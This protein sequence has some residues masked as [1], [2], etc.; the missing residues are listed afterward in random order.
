MQ[1]STGNMM[2][3]IT[4]MQEDADKRRQEVLD[5][6]DRLSDASSSD[7]AST[8]SRMYSGSHNSSISISMLPSEPKIFHGRESELSDILELFS[9]ETPRIAILGPGGIGKT[10]MARAIVHHQEIS[11][12]YRQHRFFVSCD[13]VVNKAELVAL[14]GAHL[15]LK[16][17]KDLTRPIVQH[18][19][20]SPPSLIVLDNLETLWESPGSR[21]DVEE[22]LSLVTDVEQ[23]SLLVGVGLISHEALLIAYQITMRGAERPGKVSWT[24]PFIPP[25]QPLERDAAQQTFADIADDTHNPEEVNKILSLT[26]NMPL[27]IT[28][29]AH[30]VGVE[31]CS[32]VLDRWEANKTSLISEGNDRRSS[33]DVSVSLSLSSPRIKSI[34]QAKDLLSLLSMLPDGL[35]DG[36]LMQSKLPIVDILGCKTALIR[37]ALAYIDERKQ[38]RVLVPVREHMLHHHLPGDHL[39]QPLLWHFQGL[40]KLHTE[41]SG[42]QSHYSTVNRI[43]LNFSNIENILRR[44]LKAAGL[45]AGG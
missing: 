5:M 39:V 2:L 24:R 38:L 15:G 22:F 25:L 27:A 17:D 40:L 34:P 8:I 45:L 35:S 9:K 31:G 43:L 30:L 3:D 37:T 14:I 1:M 13:S 7:T 19:T 33:V 16:P 42:S 28:L 18:F 10:S 12:R 41:Y 26:G 23:L 21:S 36:E 20:K 4:Q 44:G 6:I 29:I 32:N 11:D